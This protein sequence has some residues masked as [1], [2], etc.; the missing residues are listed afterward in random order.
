MEKRYIGI[1]LHRNQFTCC[2]RLENE[3]TYLSNWRLEDLPRF[4]KKLREGDKE[5]SSKLDVVVLFEEFEIPDEIEL[6]RAHFEFG[7]TD[8]F[9]EVALAVAPVQCG[10]RHSPEGCG[11]EPLSLLTR[12][13]I[14]RD[15]PHPLPAD[16]DLC[17]FRVSR[18]RDGFHR[19]NT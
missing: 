10:H 8:H 6:L 1:D 7:Q 16:Y 9:F 4:V 2:R 18:R 5:Q 3:R 19:T 12:Q 11:G 14:E 15:V 13:V 17:R